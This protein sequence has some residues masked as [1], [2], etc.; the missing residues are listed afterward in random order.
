MVNSEEYA[1]F[2]RFKQASS[3]GPNAVGASASRHRNDGPRAEIILGNET[4]SFLVDTG[5]PINVI[6]EQTFNSWDTRPKLELCSSR[7]YG[8]NS[9][10]PL[11]IRGQ[12]TVIYKIRY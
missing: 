12:F 3:F 5:S 9:T 2:M 11:P 4:C 6:D 10:T 8:Y 1:E 7:Y